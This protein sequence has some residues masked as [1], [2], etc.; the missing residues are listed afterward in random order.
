MQVQ[1]GCELGWHGTPPFLCEFSQSIATEV[2]AHVVIFLL[3][4]RKG[5]G[6]W[7]ERH[8]LV[9]YVSPVFWS[10][11]S[12]GMRTV[13]DEYSAGSVGEVLASWM[14]GVLI[15][16]RAHRRLDFKLLNRRLLNG[17]DHHY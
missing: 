17:V 10:F 16:G 6:T 3:V 4:R 12:V 5:L 1:P 8:L 7:Y 15:L 13:Q 9:E 11:S 2:L 14:F